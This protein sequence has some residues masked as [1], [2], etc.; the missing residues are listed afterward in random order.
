MGKSHQKILGS[1]WSYPVGTRKVKEFQVENN[2]TIIFLLK[3]GGKMDGIV[4]M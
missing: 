1:N 2:I 3:L 4:K